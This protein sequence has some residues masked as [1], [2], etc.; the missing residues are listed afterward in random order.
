MGIVQVFLALAEFD[1]QIHW[2][3]DAIELLVLNLVENF[4]HFEPLGLVLVMLMGVA[5]AE[6]A[7][8]IPSVLRWVAFGRW[9]R[10]CTS[11]LRRAVW[12]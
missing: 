11:I 7:G 12:T 6:G 1:V 9:W 8:L 5:L 3:V 2:N 10:S 4:A